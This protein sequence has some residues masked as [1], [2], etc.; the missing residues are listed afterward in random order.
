MNFTTELF[1]LDVSDHVM[2]IVHDDGVYRHL[3]FQKPGSWHMMFDVHTWPGYLC[4]TGDMGTFVF[5]RLP[6]MLEFFRRDSNQPKFQID[7]NYW[8]EKLEAVDRGD[9][10][11]EWSAA[12]FELRVKDYFDQFTSDAEEWPQPRKAALWEEIKSDVLS[13]SAE[14]EHRGL[15]ALHDFSFDGFQF[16]D[17]GYDGKVWTF[18]FLW[19]CHAL[20]WAVDKYDEVTAAGQVG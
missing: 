6:D 20:E 18:R 3:R 16:E 9:G 2:A 1:E 12:A 17:W 19:C 13:A 4:Y 5:K 14:N 7:F 15:V 10:V 8:A 11:R